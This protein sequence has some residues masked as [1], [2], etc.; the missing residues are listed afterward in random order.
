VDVQFRCL[1][2][3]TEFQ[4]VQILTGIEMDGDGL[5]RRSGSRV[6]RLSVGRALA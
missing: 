5:T 2:R 4:I 1:R 6:E 3:Q